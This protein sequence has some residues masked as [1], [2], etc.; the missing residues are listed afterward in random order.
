[1]SAADDAG[2]LDLI[3]LERQFEAR[4]AEAVPSLVAA[5]NAGPGAV[6]IVD[7]LLGAEAAAALGVLQ[8]GQI[9]KR[10][11]LLADFPAFE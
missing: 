9:G 8:V 11:A 3:E 4:I 2:N 7:N 5:L 1:M 10:T 6:A